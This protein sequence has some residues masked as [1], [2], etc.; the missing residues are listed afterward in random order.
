MKFKIFLNLDTKIKVKCRNGFFENENLLEEYISQNPDRIT[1]EQIQILQAF[2]K[3]IKGKFII[4]KCLTH[5]AILLNIDN[6][7]FYTVKALGEP[8]TNFFDYLPVLV[9]AA[10][11][12]FKGK[13]VYDGFMFQQSLIGPGIKRNLL[14]DYKEAKREKK[15]ITAIV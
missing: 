12:P 15:I 5:H 3:K 4:L 14:E 2:K 9:E 6:N 11:I 13:I 7:Q 10:I 8:F 1:D